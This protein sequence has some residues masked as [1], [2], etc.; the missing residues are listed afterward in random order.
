L[1]AG[2]DFDLPTREPPPL[3]CMALLSG[4]WSVAMV[5]TNVDWVACRDRLPPVDVVVLQKLTTQMDA[6]TSRR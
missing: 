5:A 2:E 6:E 3:K 4:G 1:A